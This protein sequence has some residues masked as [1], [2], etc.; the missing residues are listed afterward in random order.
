MS[1][2]SEIGQGIKLGEMESILPSYLYQISAHCLRR[3]LLPGQPFPQIRIFLQM[4]EVKQG[5][6]GEEIENGIQEYQQG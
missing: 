4:E 6:D 2:A 1:T 3:L 5:V